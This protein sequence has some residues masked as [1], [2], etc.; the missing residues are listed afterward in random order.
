MKNSRLS[1]IGAVEEVHAHDLARLPGR[2][3]ERTGDAV[4]IE[5]CTRSRSLADAFTVVYATVTVFSPG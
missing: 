2:E 1:T 4:E 5:R 3:R